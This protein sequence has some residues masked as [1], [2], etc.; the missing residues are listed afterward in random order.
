MNLL[1]TLVLALHIFTTTHA[2]VQCQNRRPTARRF[3]SSAVDAHIQTVA[4]KLT[5]LNQTLLACI[6]SNTLPNT[7]DTTVLQAATS[8]NETTFVITG[9]INAMWLRDSTN[10][11]LPY[12][13]FAT[14]DRNLQHLLAGLVRQQAQLILADPYAN[15]HNLN[16]I[17]G[18][19]PNINDQTTVPGFGPSRSNAMVPGIYE[20]KYELDSLCA[21][22]KLSNEYYTATKDLQPFQHP[23]WTQAVEL[24]LQVMKDMQS[25]TEQQYVQPGG[26]TYQFQRQASEP[27]DT[28]LHGVGHPGAFTGMVRS[29]FRPSDDATTLPFLVPANAM[30]VV[31][32]RKVVL[33]LTAL[34][35]SGGRLADVI[36]DA[37]TLATAIDQGIQKFGI[38]V[39]PLTGDKQYAYEVDGFGNMYYADD[40]NIPSLLSLPYLG[41]VKASDP[42]YV[43]TR[44][45]VLSNNN[46][47][48]FKGTAGEGVGGPHVGLNSIWPMSIVVRALTATDETEILDCVDLLVASTASTGLMHE[49]FNK[50]NVNDFTRPWF[51]WANSLFGELIMQVYAKY[52]DVLVAG[53]RGVVA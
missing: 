19:S 36:Q 4:S 18:P 21:F 53:R 10:Q 39:H 16:D 12:L 52:P 2:T 40:A 45:F 35:K 20:R 7:L 30:A 46:P 44:K 26:A 24:V 1:R 42:V 5:A 31:E 48:F 13:Q 47:W 49:S 27:T 29:A 17:A 8:S 38:G 41:Y 28:L 32:L 25:S 9:D 3:V 14:A 33:V 11:V 43:A 37:S 22:L 34:V 23:S 51:A 15:A 50:D 6:F